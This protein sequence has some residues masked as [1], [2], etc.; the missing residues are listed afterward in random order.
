MYVRSDK[1]F[2]KV[3]GNGISL[4]EIINDNVKSIKNGDF[5]NSA[6]YVR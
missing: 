5:S 2:N 4:K 6:A 1:T 3:D